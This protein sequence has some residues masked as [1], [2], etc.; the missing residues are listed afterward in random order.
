M[1]PGPVCTRS[2]RKPGTTAAATLAILG[3]IPLLPGEVTIPMLVVFV[4]QVAG[5]INNVWSAVAPDWQASPDRVALVTGIL[6]GAVSA[7]G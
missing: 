7:V 4:S 3:S 6:N 5:A 2:V 1:A